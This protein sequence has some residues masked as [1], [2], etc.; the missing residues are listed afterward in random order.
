[1]VFVPSESGPDEV[2]APRVEAP[3]LRIDANRF[4]DDAVV[5]KRL[6]VVALVK[7]PFVVVEKVKMAL[8]VVA[9]VVVAK[10]TARFEMVEEAVT[11]MP[12]VVDVGVIAPNELIE[13][14]L[15]CER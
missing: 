2:I 9:Y 14:S 15:N 5:E 13:K 10:S 12:R 6:V 11:K 3:A 8:V 1:M 4:V 7:M